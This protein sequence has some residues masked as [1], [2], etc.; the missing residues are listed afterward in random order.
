MLA[1]SFIY[2]FFCKGA[3]HIL[4]IAWFRWLALGELQDCS[5]NFRRP[6]WGATSYTLIIR[7]SVWVQIRQFIKLLLWRGLRFFKCVLVLNLWLE[8]IWEWSL[9]WERSTHVLCLPSGGGQLAHYQMHLL[10]DDVKS[11][12]L[13]AVLQRFEWLLLLI[14]YVQFDFFHQMLDA[15]L[16][17]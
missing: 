10:P 13:W 2:A 7:W 14:L 6:C 16:D 9:F 12:L 17:E 11:L 1:K 8:V 5:V 15:I 4:E 3:G